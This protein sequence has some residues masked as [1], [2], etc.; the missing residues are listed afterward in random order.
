MFIVHFFRISTEEMVLYLPDTIKNIR[1]LY[2]LTMAG[3]GASK[4]D[5]KTLNAGPFSGVTT[6][7][8]RTEKQRKIDEK[9]NDA[10]KEQWKQHLKEAREVCGL[11][12]LSSLKS[13]IDEVN[14]LDQ[15]DIDRLWEEFRDS[16]MIG[17][18]KKGGS[19]KKLV[20]GM[21]NTI[22]MLM[23]LPRLNNEQFLSFI[24]YVLPKLQTQ[25]NGLADCIKSFI[26]KCYADYFNVETANAIA[27]GSTAAL[28]A[29]VSALSD[30]GNMTLT[31]LR[32]M[33][34]GLHRAIEAHH[35]ASNR[36]DLLELNN[37][38]QTKLGELSTGTMK[39]RDREGYVHAPER[40][41]NPFE[42][43]S[44]LDEMAKAVSEKTQAEMEAAQVE[45]EATQAETKAQE[46]ETLRRMRNEA[47]ER[48]KAAEERKTVV[49][50]K[51]SLRK[52]LDEIKGRTPKSKTPKDVKKG[53]RRTQKHGK[54]NKH[55]KTHKK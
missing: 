55:S 14:G 42:T 15:D 2:I 31:V 16:V 17:D 24:E 45:M 5:Y 20:G 4:V 51:G 11:D 22:S 10:R 12:D 39:G 34:A 46:M 23:L 30:T 41:N 40:M 25:W 33:D 26:L 36:L 35:E 1:I 19:S 54:K 53:G 8:F 43:G 18:E 49:K 50:A 52:V 38:I 47:K 32:A 7:A 3:R 48:T 27:T 29:A 37:A 44:G 6:A 9:R 28:Q 21:L 13:A